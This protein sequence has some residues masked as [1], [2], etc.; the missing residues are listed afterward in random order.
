MR[1]FVQI[2]FVK[3]FFFRIIAF[4]KFSEQL[5]FSFIDLRRPVV[6]QGFLFSVFFRVCGLKGHV[7]LALT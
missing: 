1:Q 5:I 7:Y 2:I 3:R 6:I 4:E